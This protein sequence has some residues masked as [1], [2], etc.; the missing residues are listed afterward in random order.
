MGVRQ[1]ELVNKFDNAL[2]GV[3]GDS[4]TIAPF[5]NL[6][7]FLETASFWDMQKCP[8]PQEPGVEDRTQLDLGAGRNACRRTSCSARSP[9]CTSAAALPIYP[10]PPTCNRRGLTSLGD[11]TITRLAAK[12]MLFD[13]DHMSVKARKSSMDR[14]EQLE[15]PGR[16]CPA[17]P[18]RRLTSTR[19]S[20]RRAV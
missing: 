4:G 5:V 10:A 12:K 9:S 3:A 1:M 20:T 14:I 8:A 15:L 19:A 13:P 11:H 6:A 18:G 17:T 16:H 2:A 7:N